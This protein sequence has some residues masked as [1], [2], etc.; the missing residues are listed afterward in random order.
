MA[1][2]VGIGADPGV[3]GHQPVEDRLQSGAHELVAV[4]HGD[5]FVLDRQLGR[6][7]VQHEPAVVAPGAQSAGGAVGQAEGRVIDHAEQR[8]ALVEQPDDDAVRGVCPG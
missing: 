4:A 3:A 7:V 1:E 6:Q 5:R 8:F 2:A